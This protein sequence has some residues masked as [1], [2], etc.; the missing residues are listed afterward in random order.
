MD[1]A[2][3]EVDILVCPTVPIPT[4]TRAEA[5]MEQGERVW[6]IVAMITR[7]TRPFSYLGLPVLSVPAGQDRNGMPVGVQLIG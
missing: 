4:P 7:L 3:S 5:D 2:F 1:E 6:P